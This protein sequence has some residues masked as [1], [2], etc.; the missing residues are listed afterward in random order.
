MPALQSPR[1]QLR[2][3]S[4]AFHLKMRPFFGALFSMRRTRLRMPR[5]DFRLWD[6]I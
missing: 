1:L 6:M 4:I 5:G 2:H 3:L